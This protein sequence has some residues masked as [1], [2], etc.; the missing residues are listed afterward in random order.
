[1]LHV[2]GIPNC[3]TVKKARTWLE[4]NDIHYCF[5]NFKQ[6]IPTLEQL[7]EWCEAVGWETLLNKQSSTWRAL[8]EEEKAGAINTQA[9][10]Q[11]MLKN[12]SIIKRPVVTDESGAVLSV[13]FKVENFEA[14]ATA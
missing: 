3:D 4:Q 11:L 9:A 6:E 10:V 5:H 12:T 13:G 7:T 14:L 8:S 2:Y 1:M